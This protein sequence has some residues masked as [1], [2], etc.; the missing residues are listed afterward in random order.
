M[1]GGLFS[2]LLLF[3]LRTRARP[4]TEKNQ[5]SHDGNH[6]PD[7]GATVGSVGKLDKIAEST[8][9][10]R[11]PGHDRVPKSGAEGDHQKHNAGSRHRFSRSA[12]LDGKEK[13]EEHR[14]DPQQDNDGIEVTGR[15]EQIH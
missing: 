10:K 2:R 9:Q 5:H 8:D 12:M 6:Q 3:F 7:R 14:A 11:H 15:I 13:I 4:P 1:N